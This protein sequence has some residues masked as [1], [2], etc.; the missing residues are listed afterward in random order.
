M[1]EKFG[2]N[3][4]MLSRQ[5]AAVQRMIGGL[6]KMCGM[7]NI[8]PIVFVMEIDYLNTVNAN[9]LKNITNEG[10]DPK[11]VMDEIHKMNVERYNAEKAPKK[12]NYRELKSKPFN[13]SALFRHFRTTHK[14]V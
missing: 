12:G 6:V 13:E 3:E 9:S 2:M 5:M 1:L 10:V 14:H 8:H 4:E 7:L 11:M